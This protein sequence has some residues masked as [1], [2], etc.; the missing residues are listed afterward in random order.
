MIPKL[1]MRSIGL[2]GLDGLEEREAFALRA[3]PAEPGA[4]AAER[5]A[6]YVR[7]AG[8]VLVVWLPR[9]HLPNRYQR[10]VSWWFL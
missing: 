8:I 2:D 5:S 6:A 3:A 10:A 4:A 9:S 1:R 7:V